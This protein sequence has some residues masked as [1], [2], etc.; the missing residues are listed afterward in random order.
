LNPRPVRW[1]APAAATI[2]DPLL[3]AESWLLWI[4]LGAVFLALVT[5]IGVVSVAARSEGE[6]RRLERSLRAYTTGGSSR[7]HRHHLDAARFSRGAGNLVDRL[8]KP[9]G[10]DA[11]LQRRID[12][13]SW[14]LRASEF[15]A[16][17][18]GATA[19][20]GLLAWAL[21]GSLAFLMVGGAVGWF[22]PRAVLDH[23][24]RTR[25]SAFME[26]LP[27]TLQLMAGSLKAGYGLVQAIDTV[28]RESPAPTSE[29]FSRVL[30]ETRLGM[31]LSEALEG[32]AERTD[33]EDF[34]WV[35]MAINIQSQVGGN[36][37]QLLETVA[38]TLREREQVRRQ[39]KTLS[40]EGKLSA[41]VLIGLVPAMGLYMLASNPE[42]VSQ[43]W[44]TSMGRTMSAIGL[45][46]VAGGILGIKKVITIE[47]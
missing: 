38:G 8:P 35:V 5:M 30:T 28:V 37:A 3:P 40:A 21:T 2:A 43:L 31:G 12:Q 36:L 47:V 41:W 10:F 45:A 27:D 14:P 32:M 42:Y 13:T 29:E 4:G 22:V 39:V 1:S 19:G 17:Q 26:Q 24:V 23:R 9:A 25:A 16:L 33:S 18:I 46:G 15:V 11:A 6:N 44:T 34:G 7:G 20:I